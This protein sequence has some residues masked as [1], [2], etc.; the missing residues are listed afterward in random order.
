MDLFKCLPKRM[1]EGR[2][3]LKI[4]AAEH[5]QAETG[6]EI[7]RLTLENEQGATMCQ[8]F[9]DTKR[10]RPYL[11]SMAV[12]CGLTDDEMKDF[13]IDLLVQRKIIGD[14]Q[15]NAE[16]FWC[17]KSWAPISANETGEDC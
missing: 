13:D 16:Q 14:V 2:Q 17:L 9:P 4:I 10:G 12:A 15:M 5:H 3:T 7:Y 6:T 8:N 1:R 11:A